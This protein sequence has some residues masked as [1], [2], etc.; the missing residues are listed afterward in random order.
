MPYSDI[1]D[2]KKEIPFETIR[3]LVDDENTGSLTRQD[4]VD[5]FNAI[6]DESDSEMDASLEAGGY[7]TPVTAPASAL[8]M[9]KSWSKARI[10]YKLYNRKDIMP[11]TRAAEFNRVERLLEKVSQGTFKLPGGEKTDT[12]AVTGVGITTITNNRFTVTT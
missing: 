3:Q 11:E 4:V 7:T 8:T 12:A 10:A 2:Q 5:R 1:E 9:L 6:R